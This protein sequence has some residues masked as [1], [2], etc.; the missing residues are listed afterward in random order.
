MGLLDK[1]RK[2][3]SVDSE[4][5]ADT[6]TDSQP[7]A[8][9]LPE[10]V[11]TTKSKKKS[12]PKIKPAKKAKENTSSLKDRFEANV[13]KAKG[14][15]A[16]W[17]WEGSCTEDGYGQFWVGDNKVV[18]THRF[19]FELYRTKIPKGKRLRNECGEKKCVNPFHWEIIERVVYVPKN[20]K[21]KS[22]AK[23]STAKR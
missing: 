5:I 20:K 19:S 12:T 22:S 9:I 15:N 3:T 11:K 1:F 18:K 6:K 4:I 2:K 14:K 16:H 21:K 13:K 10:K 7:K 23:K 17:S 8:T